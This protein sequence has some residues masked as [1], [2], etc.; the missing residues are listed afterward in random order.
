MSTVISLY[1]IKPVV[2]SICAAI[3]PQKVKVPIVILIAWAEAIGRLYTGLEDLYC[4]GANK[5]SS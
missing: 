5:F 1:R 3:W 4:F 2:G